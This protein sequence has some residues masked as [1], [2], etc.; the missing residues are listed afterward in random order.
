MTLDDRI[1]TCR[2]QR[3]PDDVSPPLSIWRQT[4]AT[5]TPTPNL[6]HTLNSQTHAKASAQPALD[7]R[8]GS[9]SLRRCTAAV[10]GELGLRDKSPIYAEQHVTLRRH[11]GLTLTP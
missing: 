10:R 11:F 3:H 9:D 5:N 6:M 7:A 4:T 8:T 1:E 2:R